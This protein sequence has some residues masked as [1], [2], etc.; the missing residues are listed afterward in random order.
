MEDKTVPYIVYEGEQARNERT[1]KRL[2]TA[3]I[4]AVVVTLATN[5]LWLYAWMQ[6]DF[7]YEDSSINYAQDGA[8]LNIIGNENR[9]N[10][11]ADSESP[12]GYGQKD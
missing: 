4:I 10:D 7:V 2:I 3:L 1:T 6:Y 9:V 12:Q 8:G 11:G 5:A